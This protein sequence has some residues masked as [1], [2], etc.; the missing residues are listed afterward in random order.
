MSTDFPR[1]PDGDDRLH[2]EVDRFLAGDMTPAERVAFEAR[3]AGDPALADALRAHR[4]VG[5]ALAR[6]FVVPALITPS[7]DDPPADAPPSA[8]GDGSAAAASAESAAV[9]GLSGAMIAVWVAAGAALIIGIVVGVRAL[10]TP[11]ERTRTDPVALL[12]GDGGAAFAAQTAQTD[13]ALLSVLLSDKLGR[14]VSISGAPGVEYLGV[15]SAS[16]GS[17]VRI[18]VLARVD[19]RP[20]IVVL[21]LQGFTVGTASLEAPAGVRRHDAAIGTLVATEWSVRLSP[22]ILPHITAD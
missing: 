9:T 15:H 3:C 5:H 18:A 12:T 17:S 11:D 6:L 20:A 2:G 7:L 4:A 10:S 21:D 13:P 19:G 14:R 16:G 22:A 8:P 1:Q